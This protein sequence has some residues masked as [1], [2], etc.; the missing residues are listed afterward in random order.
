[1]SA[2][3]NSTTWKEEVLL[4]DGSKIIVER[5]FTTNPRGNREIGQSAPK[6]E[7]TLQFTPPGTSQI[8]AWNSDYGG[9]LQDNL[10]LLG[11]DVVKGTP[12]LVTTPNRCHAFNKWGRPNPP[13]VVLKYDGQTWQ[14]IDIA[15]L[16]LE[17]K[18]ANVLL[19]GWG[20][21]HIKQLRGMGIDPKLTRPY[22]QLEVVERFN[23]YGSSPFEQVFVRDPMPG[24]SCDEMVYE[25]GRWVGTAAFL[26]PQMPIAPPL[27]NS[28]I[29]GKKH[30]YTIPNGLRTHG[31]QCLPVHA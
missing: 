27:L 3:S 1:M 26:H 22:V 20:D 9:G 6:A 18:R 29:K 21:D 5:G 11:L 2:C 14:R 28:H 23:R 15:Q 31:G 24:P 13:Y 16:P 4:H 7:E 8:I 19:G 17:I 30:A 12:Y 25:N 10:Q